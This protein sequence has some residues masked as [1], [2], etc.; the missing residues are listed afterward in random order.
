MDREELTK[1]L[2]SGPIRI[3][4]NDGSTYDV[5][6]REFATVS[7]I[8]ASILYKAPDGKWRHHH[9]SLVTMAGVEEL[10]PQG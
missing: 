4:M 7:D 9:L 5:P 6:S 3:T 1:L 2:L 10:Q 8:S